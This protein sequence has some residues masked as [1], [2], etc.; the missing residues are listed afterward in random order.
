MTQKHVKLKPVFSL[1]QAHQVLKNS[2]CHQQKKNQASKYAIVI[3][4]KGSF[5]ICQRLLLIFFSITMKEW[6]LLKN[7]P[8]LRLEYTNH[9]LFR[10][11]LAE[12]PYPLKLQ[13]PV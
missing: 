10:T 13:I 5:I 4:N 1:Q 3:L 8:I 9:T 11:N 2:P 6:L 12:K 7:I